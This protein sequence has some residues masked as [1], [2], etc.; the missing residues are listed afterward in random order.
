ML[1]F[2]LSGGEVPC[3][4]MV[5]RFDNDSLQLRIPVSRSPTSTSPT[6]A[7]GELYLPTLEKVWMRSGMIVENVSGG[8]EGMDRTPPGANE[9]KMWRRYG[10][11][12]EDG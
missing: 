2:F 9:E 10:I 6:S 5:M 12:V 3:R 1:F 4:A 7:R 8:K 11:S